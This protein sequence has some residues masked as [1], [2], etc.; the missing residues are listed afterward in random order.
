[1]R[2]A[3]HRVKRERGRA[4]RSMVN[5]EEEIKGRARGHSSLRF[6][7]VRIKRLVGRAAQGLRGAIN[8]NISGRVS[9]SILAGRVIACYQSRGFGRKQ[10]EEQ[11]RG[12]LRRH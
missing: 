9:F 3:I 2:A 8:R 12:L 1:M 6:I 5:R 11:D 10:L 7:A 4:R